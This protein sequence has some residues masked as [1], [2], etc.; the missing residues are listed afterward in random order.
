MQMFL[1]DPSYYRHFH[2]NSPLAIA[3]DLYGVKDAVSIN[4]SFLK[5]GQITADLVLF[6]DQQNGTT[7]LGC[8]VAANAS[9]LKNKIAFID[10]GSC[11]FTTKFLNAQ[12]AGALGIV[13]ANYAGNDTLIQMGGTDNT[14]KIPG[15]FISGD[16]GTGLKSYLGSTVNA[17]L[18]GPAIDGEIDNTIPTHEYTH[19][20]SNRLVGGPQNVSC[21]QNKEQMGEGWSD[22][23]ALMITQNWPGSSVSGDHV[24]TVG[25]YAIGFDTILNFGIRTYPYSTNM[26]INPWTYDSL[27]SLPIGI[28]TFDPHTVGEIWCEMLWDLTWKLVNDYGIGNNIFN[29]TQTGGNNIALSLITEGL[30]LTSCSPGFVDARD[31][32]LKADTT[33]YSGKYSKDIWEVFASRGLGYSAK[34]GSSNNTRDQV[35]AYDLPVVL[36]VTF[37]NFT[38]EKQ[39]STALLKWTTAQESNSDEFVIERSDDGKSF[40]SIG[41]VKASGFSASEKAYQFTDVTPLKG[42]NSYHIKE[43]DKD[44]QATYSEIRSLNFD[45]IKPS[46]KISPNPATNI[47]TINIPGNNQNLTIRLLSNAGQL[48]KNYV[49]TNDVLTINVSSLASGMYNITIDGN[50]YTAKYKLVIQ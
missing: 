14:I 27:A 16:N 4:N 46:I 13:V 31:G 23:Y 38:A 41:Q 30:K 15:I 50:S 40:N 21:L 20:I 45:D 43:V 11:S 5:T 26:N 34:E 44:G 19:G 25:N 10:R 8:N 3:Q 18:Y 2:I 48:I 9:A 28:Q 36:P 1:F 29:S 6:N 37:G 7:H 49:M 33:L 24:R 47:V 35:A 17:T 12:A 39:S 42:S 22:W 32:I